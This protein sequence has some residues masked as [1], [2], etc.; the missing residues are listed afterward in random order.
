MLHADEY[1]DV[2]IP[3]GGE[4]LIHF[5]TEHSRVPVIKHYKGVCHVYVDGDAD[6][7]KAYDICF[8]AK[9]QRPGVCNAME[10][11]L[12]DRRVAAEFL[13]K[14]AEKYG[15]AG[16]VL[17][18]CDETR[19]V[20]EVDPATN[21]DY[22]SEYLD[23]VLAIKVVGGIDG[24]IDH[25]EEFASDH[26]ESIISENPETVQCFLNRIQSSVVMANASTRFSDGG[27]MGLG[28]EIGISTSKLHAYGPMGVTDLTTRKFVVRGNGQIRN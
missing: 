16:V 11:L 25:I 12:V 14:M 7:A 27:E 18:G 6:L 17:R 22:H 4:S 9:V 19:A 13:P 5:V 26:T 28:A 8:N 15:T 1:I 10:T 2:I 23:L 24:A 20:I 3:R 21:E